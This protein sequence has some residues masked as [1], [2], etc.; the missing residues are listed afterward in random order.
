MSGDVKP[1]DSAHLSWPDSENVMQMLRERA[2]SYKQPVSTYSTAILA[3]Y[4]KLASENANLRAE[5]D[6]ARKDTVRLDAMEQYTWSAHKLSSHIGWSIVVGVQW[7]SG[8]TLRE[9]IDKAAEQRVQDLVMRE[10]A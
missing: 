9:T 8:S 3:A 10:G 2:W 7:V 5:L 1:N 6:A 4:D